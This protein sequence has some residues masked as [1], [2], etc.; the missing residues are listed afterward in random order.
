MAGKTSYGTVPKSP[1]F[2]GQKFREKSMEVISRET[3]I[4]ALNVYPYSYIQPS[5]T[6]P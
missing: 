1:G 3:R 6:Y 4:Y 2:G 5:R